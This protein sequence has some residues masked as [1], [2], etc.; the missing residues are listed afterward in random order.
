L[1]QVGEEPWG[2][3]DHPVGRRSRSVR[4]VLIEQPG[5]HARPVIYQVGPTDLTA[6]KKL[7]STN[8]PKRV[9]AREKNAKS[10]YKDYDDYAKRSE[11]WKTKRD[12]K[13]NAVLAIGSYLYHGTSREVARTVKAG[14]LSPAR[15]SFRGDVWD[16]SR[17][18]FLSM[19]TK[20]RGV[21]IKPDSVIL[22]MTVQAIPGSNCKLRPRGAPVAS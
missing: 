10:S 15:P 21:T 9:T 22:R 2:R 4:H 11:G 5:L 12:E 14:V 19:T 17:D 18:D 6:S 7:L 20:L 8:Q 13:E 3:P 1:I 16:A